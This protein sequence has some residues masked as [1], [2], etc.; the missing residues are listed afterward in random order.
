MDVKSQGLP[1]KHTVFHNF[2]SHGRAMDSHVF[3]HKFV[4]VCEAAKPFIHDTAV[5]PIQLSKR[6][7]SFWGS[8]HHEEV[9]ITILYSCSCYAHGHQ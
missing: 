9:Y 1:M 5:N 6:I 3:V 2:E 4:I 8:S 7:I